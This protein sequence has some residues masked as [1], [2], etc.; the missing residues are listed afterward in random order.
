MYTYT[1]INTRTCIWA[2]K[3]DWLLIKSQYKH[4][5]YI[6]YIY[7]YV[8]IYM[9]IQTHI[10]VR[11]LEKTLV[12]DWVPIQTRLIYIYVYIRIYIYIQI[13]V[14]IQALEKKLA[15]DRVP[16]QTH[17]HTHTRTHA[18]THTADANTPGVPIKTH[19]TPVLG[20]RT[21]DVYKYV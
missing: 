2:L 1:Y 11:A 10:Y 17:T 5:S 21:F 7:V 19:L 15:S 12:S 6:L 9:Y 4:T 13:Y 16:I 14:Y 20:Y 3:R 8:C 18:H